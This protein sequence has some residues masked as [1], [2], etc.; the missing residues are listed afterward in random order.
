MPDSTQSCSSSIDAARDSR[1]LS[2]TSVLIRLPNRCS[3]MLLGMC[4]GRNPGIWS[5]LLILALTLPNRAFT[6]PAPAVNLTT[7]PS[8]SLLIIS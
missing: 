1:R 5:S 7:T 4:P 6:S 3:S 2:A 8:P